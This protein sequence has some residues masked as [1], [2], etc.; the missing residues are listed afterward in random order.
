MKRNAIVVAVFVFFA[1]TPGLLCGSAP[2][3]AAPFTPTEPA[4]CGP[5][6]ALAGLVDP[7]PLA[8]NCEVG[9]ERDY[10]ACLSQCFPEDWWT[11]ERCFTLRHECR[12]ACP[13]PD[14]IECAGQ[15]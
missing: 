10:D 7:I 6:T 12:C 1:W 8:V 13:N 5:A 14:Q 15:P 2:A 3:I 4:L 11:C 9:C